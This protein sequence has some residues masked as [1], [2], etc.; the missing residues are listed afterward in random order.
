MK[1]RLFKGEHYTYVITQESSIQENPNEEANLHQKLGMKIRQ[2]VTD[3]LENG[4]FVIEATILNFNLELKYNG[5]ITRYDSDTINV[6]N[7]YYKSLNFLT[8]Y[9]FN[10]EVSPE[11]VVSKLSG[12][13]PIKKK[14]ENDPPLSALLRSFG[15]EQFL[16]GFYNYVPLKNVG[17]GDKWIGS[18]IL[19]DMMN[20]KYDIHY[21]FK[22][23]LAQSMKLKQEASLN[24]SAEMP[25][26]DGR[27]GKMRE[28]GTQNGSLSIDP[29]TRMCLSSDINQQIM[30]ILPTNEK[31]E[32]DKTAPVKII[33]QTKRLLVKK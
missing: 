3:K 24:Y 26:K 13:E 23:A 32:G 5:K 33:T 10:Y 4:N 22:E 18:G 8:L 7:K 15:S 20:V 30:I 21:S 19:P 14:I 2:D 25:M 28:T 16:L 17:V 31:L 1:L 29:K 11:G 12:F 27:T 6:M 9:K